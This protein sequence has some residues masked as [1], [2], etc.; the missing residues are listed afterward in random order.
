MTVPDVPRFRWA[1][2]TTKA[3]KPADRV[4]DGER[5]VNDTRAPEAE[6]IAQW[7]AEFEAAL[8]R[9]AATRLKYAFVHTHK[10]GLDDGPGFRSFAPPSSTARGATATCQHGSGTGVMIRH[11]QIEE[12]R[13]AFERHGV[14]YLFIGKSGALLYGFPDTTQDADLF[15]LKEP[16]NGKALVRALRD[17][18]FDI[19]EAQARE[20]EQGK[21]FVQVRN[22]PFDVDLVFAPD[23][24]EDFEQAWKRGQ[25]RE[26]F[27]VCALDDIIESKRASNRA[28]D[29]ESLPRLREFRNYL[30]ERG[31][32]GGARLPRRDF[33]DTRSGTRRT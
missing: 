12:I 4:Q 2:Y 3:T 32:L 20:I 33:A 25:S 28:K 6:T 23:G 8:A 31:Q 9:P 5:N 11:T 18:G 27:P 15:P 10:P 7:R 24:I 21:D 30:D 17:I 22:G 16:E 14:V 29:R 26:R 1:K 13:D 19:D